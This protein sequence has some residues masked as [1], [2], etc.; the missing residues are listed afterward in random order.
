MRT[1]DARALIP[2]TIGFACL[3]VMAACRHEATAPVDGRAA[4]D[5]WHEAEEQ[6]AA[7]VA[8]EEYKEAAARTEACLER[9]GYPGV[10]GAIVLSDGTRHEPE[11]QLGE[12][13]AVT[14]ALAEYAAAK[15]RC[16]AES[17]LDS[18][19]QGV[20]PEALAGERQESV[21]ARNEQFIAAISCLEVRGW[22]F[23]EVLTIFG[24]LL[25]TEPILG[26][27]EQDAYDLDVAECATE[28]SNQ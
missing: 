27:G 14:Y 12:L 8:S 16:E 11:G 26:P 21:R 10:D 5:L 20:F 17:G 4:D 23:R 25:F 19:E 3:V 22:T 13:F 28:L 2:S 1:F 18:L 15:D 6:H 9:A 24:G 7:L